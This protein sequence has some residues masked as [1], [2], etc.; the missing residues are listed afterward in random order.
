MP[1]TGSEYQRIPFY[2]QDDEVLKQFAGR[3]R[4]VSILGQGP[5][6]SAPGVSA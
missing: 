4:G 2:C 3:G 5:N 6:Q 1:E